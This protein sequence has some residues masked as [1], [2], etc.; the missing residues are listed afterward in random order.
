MVTSP[1]GMPKQAVVIRGHPRNSATNTLAVAEADAA[2]VRV[3]YRCC[4]IQ[5]GYK[6]EML[7]VKNGIVFMPDAENIDRRRMLSFSLEGLGVA[8]VLSY[9]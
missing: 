3:R 2:H 1:Y 4:K 7:A 6:S 8:G 9:W 5:L